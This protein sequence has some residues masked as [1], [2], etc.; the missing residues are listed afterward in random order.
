MFTFLSALPVIGPIISFFK[1]L[2]GN[3]LTVICIIVVIGCAVFAFWMWTSQTKL[4]GQLATATTT[5]G[6]L[7]TAVS[8][9]KQAVQTDSETIATLKNLRQNDNLTLSGLTQDYQNLTTASQALK[10]RIYTLEKSDAKVKSYL[11]EP[12]PADLSSL[13]TSGQ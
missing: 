9:Y 7:N 6:T 12:V 10:T 13:L 2:G 11:D 8:A 5:I 1:N 3:V 4:K